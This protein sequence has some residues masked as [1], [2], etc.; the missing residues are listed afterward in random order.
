MPAAGA[1]R[2]RVEKMSRP[3]L[4][5]EYYKLYESNQNLKRKLNE[6]EEKLKKYEFVMFSF[7]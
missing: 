7:K 2:P 5:D 1:Y 6:T 4:E 3:V